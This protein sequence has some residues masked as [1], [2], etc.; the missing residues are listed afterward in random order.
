MQVFTRQQGQVFGQVRKNR[1]DR[2]WKNLNTLPLKKSL[3][4]SML[5]MS[6]FFKTF[7]FYLKSIQGKT[8]PDSFLECASFFAELNLLITLKQ[9]SVRN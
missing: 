6:T 4:E 2:L 9:H 3:F 7:L 5:P 8:D 1:S